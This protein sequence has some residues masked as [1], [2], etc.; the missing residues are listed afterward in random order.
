MTRKYRS[1]QCPDCE[2]NRADVFCVYEYGVKDTQ[3]SAKTS[4]FIKGEF[5]KLV[6][7]NIKCPDY[8]PIIVVSK[9][10]EEEE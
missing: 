1:Y 10:L 7:T 9:V 2:R 6:E 4:K 5:N 3:H 8:T